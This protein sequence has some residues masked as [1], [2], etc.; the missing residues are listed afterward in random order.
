MRSEAVMI[1]M[2]DLC[3]GAYLEAILSPGTTVIRRQFTFWKLSLS[4]K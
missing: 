1:K 2:T 4:L 3:G